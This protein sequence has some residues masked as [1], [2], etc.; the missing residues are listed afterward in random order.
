MN[1]VITLDTVDSTNSY[2][3]RN[4]DLW[5]PYLVVRALEQTA[6]RGRYGRNWFSGPGDLTFSMV[7]PCESDFPYWVL[8]LYSGLALYNSLQALGVDVSVKWPNDILFGNLKCAGI[9]C[10]RSGNSPVIAGIG[11]NINTDDDDSL[12]P[13]VSLTQVLNQQIRVEELFDKIIIDQV[14]MFRRAEY[15]LTEEF[16]AAY[17][18]AAGYRT[19]RLNDDGS[20]L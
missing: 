3:L 7:V 11:I 1:R 8:S 17:S 12:L 16:R 2:L 10:E 9:L 6:G 18:E 20:L 14:N 13:K 19:M 5:Q 15:P 4:R